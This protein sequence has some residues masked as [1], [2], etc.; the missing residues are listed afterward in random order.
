[1][2]K[3]KSVEEAVMVEIDGELVEM[4]RDHLPEMSD[5]GDLGGSDASSCFD[6]SRATVIFDDAFKYFIDTFGDRA[7]NSTQKFDVIVMDGKLKCLAFHG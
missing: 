2:L 3:H 1:M 7:E 6:D 5:C 4:C